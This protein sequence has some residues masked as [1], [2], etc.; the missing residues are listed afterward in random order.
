MT[1]DVRQ[2]YGTPHEDKSKGYMADCCATRCRDQSRGHLPVRFDPLVERLVARLA[3]KTWHLG[4]PVA[5]CRRI[6]GVAG[7]RKG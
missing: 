2:T 7:C 5:P 6:V 3:D 1:F 4:M